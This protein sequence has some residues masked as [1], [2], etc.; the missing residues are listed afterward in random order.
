MGHSINAGGHDWLAIWRRMY[1]EERAQ[2]EAA[3]D[4]AFERHNDYWA[5]RAGRF[6]ASSQ[7]QGQPDGFM[8]ALL[9]RLRPTDTVL[10]IGAGTGRYLPILSP[11]VRHVIAVEPSPAMRTE[12]ERLIA[13]E[14]L[15]NITVVADQ[16]PSSQPIPADVVFSAHVVY[17]VADV[18]PF[19]SA[20]DR[21]ALRTCHL[22][23]GIEHPGHG[24]A[25]FWEKIHG[26]VRRALPA[27]I[28]ALACLYQLGIYASLDLIPMSGSFRFANT[29]D[30]LVE[31]RH[32]LR[33]APEAD[34]DA[35]IAAA[36]SD[37]LL[38]DAEGMLRLKDQPSHAA[39]I[40]WEPATKC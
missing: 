40:S 23:L 10:D 8:Q 28:E 27:A 34:R 12:M 1:E 3:T 14:G 35:Q 24:L 18:G 22:Y 15:S 6:A 13:A 9:P 39:M 16:W 11:V 37:L 26:E 25:A 21:S 29:D 20:M 33:L 7:Q 36:I 38:P 31:I 5:N 32:R 19:F 2:G 17:G 4:A 30:A